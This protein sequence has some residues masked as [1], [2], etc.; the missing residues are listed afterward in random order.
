MS[1]LNTLSGSIFKLPAAEPYE[2]V[3]DR[4]IKIRISDG[5]DLLVGRCYPRKGTGLPRL[6][7]KSAI[8]MYR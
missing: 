8:T 7:I 3:A 5:V 4:D 6:M 2:V 1:F